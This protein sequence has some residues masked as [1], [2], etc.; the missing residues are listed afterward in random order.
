MCCCVV[1][2]TIV[3]VTAITLRTI[4]ISLSTTS[5]CPN[6]SVVHNPTLDAANLRGHRLAY[7]E[8][9]LVFRLNRP[10]GSA[11]RENTRKQNQRTAAQKTAV[12]SQSARVTRTEK[13]VDG[14]ANIFCSRRYAMVKYASEQSACLRFCTKLVRNAFCHAVNFEKNTKNSDSREKPST[15]DSPYKAGLRLLADAVA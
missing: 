5:L 1:V 14:F 2:A 15:V 13:L 4:P 11:E 7:L 3:V 12:E 6:L 9:V 8:K 10:Q